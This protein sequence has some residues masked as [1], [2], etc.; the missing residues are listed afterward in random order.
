MLETMPVTAQD[1]MTRKVF[2]V[3]SDASLLEAVR[4]M[5][6][7]QISGV[8]VV[9]ENDRPV[10]VLTEGDLLRFHGEFNERQTAWL[11]RL[12]EG[13][14]LAGDFIKFLQ[15]GSR[16]VSR[17]MTTGVITVTPDTPA[18]SIARIFFDHG[19]KRVPVVDAGGKLVG[20]VSRA[21]LV[22]AFVKA[23]SAPPSPP[24]L[25]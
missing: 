25:D 8:V 17:L 23:L 18:W 6:D 11:G 22:R 5:A 9:D 1:V 4:L 15:E 3:R 24:T 16:R 13:T 19:I 12:S 10:G 14:E 2:V 21:D 7:H 20:I